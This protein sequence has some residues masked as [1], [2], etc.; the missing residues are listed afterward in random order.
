MRS[1][2]GGLFSEA[3][4]NESGA[5]NQPLLEMGYSAK[6]KKAQVKHFTNPKESESEAIYKFL[7]RADRSVNL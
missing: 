2:G 3:K 7:S 4:E 1:P 6:Q 5:I